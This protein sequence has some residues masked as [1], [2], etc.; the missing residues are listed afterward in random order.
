M[1]VEAMNDV[2]A[3]CHVPRWSIVPVLRSQSVGEHSFRA[4][5][6][7][8][9]MCS[10]LDLAVDI[11][12]LCW[13]LIHDGAE[14]RTGDVPAGCDSTPLESDVC[15][16]WH[17][18]KSIVSDRDRDL[19]KVAD[20]IETASYVTMY[21][22]GSHAAGVAWEA[23]ERALLKAEQ[24]GRDHGLPRLQEVAS[25]L[26]DDIVSERGRFVKAGGVR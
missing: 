5:I 20:Y 2:L 21:G 14:S 4:T 1:S 12:G 23:R 10:N 16:W 13:V 11:R 6:I 3:L 9:E 25:K 17:R 8:L 22:V 18:S 7:Y 26:Y 19:V 24:A 15:A